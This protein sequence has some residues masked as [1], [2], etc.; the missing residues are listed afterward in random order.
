MGERHGR[1]ILGSDVD[2]SQPIARVADCVL[3]ST[4]EKSLLGENI[5]NHSV[6]RILKLILLPARSC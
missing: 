2:L 1:K 5:E 6:L 4:R 3:T